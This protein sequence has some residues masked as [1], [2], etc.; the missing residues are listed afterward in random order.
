MLARRFILGAF[1]AAS[2]A[3]VGC[4]GEGGP[5]LSPVKGVVKYN[6]A[7]VQGA[8]VSFLYESGQLAVG[9][10]DASG[11]F[12]LTTNGR[13]GAPLGAAKVGVNKV[14]TAAGGQD[15]TTMK[16]EDMQKMQMEIMK[17]GNQAAA[18]PPLPLKYQ[19]PSKSGLTAEVA[20]GGVD[21]NTFEFNLVD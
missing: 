16:P 15:T 14:D 1:L 7:P 6:G 18:K 8:S 20:A 10:T 19:D 5:S 13:P 17:R 2:A 4:G 3:F 11:S 21:K 12:S 9:A